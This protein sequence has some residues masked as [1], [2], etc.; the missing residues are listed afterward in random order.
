M[1]FFTEIKHLIKPTFSLCGTNS[2]HC[3]LLLHALIPHLDLFT[4]FGSNISFTKKAWT[5]IYRLR[6]MR[7]SD[8]YDKRIQE[9]FPA[10]D[11]LVLLYGC[12]TK[13]LTKTL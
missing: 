4:Y 2:I 6:T 5:A 7:K 11:M 3:F 1:S 8:F 9:F 13:I 10:V 12:S